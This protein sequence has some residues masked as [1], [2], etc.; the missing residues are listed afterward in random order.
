[1]SLMDMAKT[2]QQEEQGK[3]FILAIIMDG[4]VKGGVITQE[5]QNAIN[6]NKAEGKRLHMEFVACIEKKKEK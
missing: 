4:L 6:A 3:D 5:L 1:M 2:E